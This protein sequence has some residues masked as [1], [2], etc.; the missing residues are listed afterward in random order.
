MNIGQAI[1]QDRQRLGLTQG[2][3]A[4]RIGVSQQSVSK[5]EDGLSVPRGKRLD[6]IIRATGEGSLTANAIKTLTKEKDKEAMYT[7]PS[8]ETVAALAVLAKAAADIAQ[9]AQKIAD[10]VVKIAGP[11]QKPGKRPH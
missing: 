4:R 10:S 9:A 5:W 7:P 6:Q 11:H 3:F 8:P 1:A 2:E